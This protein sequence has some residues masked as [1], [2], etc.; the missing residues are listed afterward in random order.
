M[1]KNTSIDIV[2]ENFQDMR[3]DIPEFSAKNMHYSMSGVNPFYYDILNS[4]QE[5]QFSPLAASLQATDPLSTALPATITNVVPMFNG[6]LTSLP[7]IIIA[8]NAG[9]IKN[10]LANTTRQPFGAGAQI[11][12]V[13]PFGGYAIM[14]SSIS[15]QIAYCLLGANTVFTL[16]T[17]TV[18]GVG[19]KYLCAFLD[20]LLIC[21]S[22]NVFLMTQP[23]VEPSN[24]PGLQL[25]S[26]YQI[27]AP[28]EV[29][30]NY[31]SIPG[32]ADLYSDNVLFLWNGYGTTYQYNV[33]LP[34]RFIGQTNINGVLFVVVEEK[35]GIQ[36][37]FYVK[38]EVL[39]RVRKLHGLHT[40]AN[41][42]IISNPKLYPVFNANGYVCILTDQGVYFYKKDVY[43][44]VSFIYN[45]N[46]YNAGAV[47]G[48]SNQLYLASGTNLYNDLSSVFNPV[49]YNSQYIPV[50]PG[51][52]D[53]WYDTPPQ[54]GTDAIN[55]TLYGIDEFGPEGGLAN[56]NFPL[57]SITPLNTLGSDSAKR[58]TLDC[59][60][61]T[62][63]KCRISLSTV[64]SAWQP[65]IRKLVITP[66][67]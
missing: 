1:A 62:G 63:Q 14:V 39:I 48:L 64:N 43:G 52:I 50:T 40:T 61:F 49:V 36:S 8:D 31:V 16:I 53:V 44:E 60:G 3:S 20:Y 42:I 7:D 25:P 66:A 21:Q 59:T 47:G 38:G 57:T 13:L 27:I 35:S 54:S 32:A 41:S 18:V 12:S 65:I 10:G 11:V 51:K 6:A 28:P 4:T 24:V 56:T 23:T 46:N 22:N 30:G 37:L 17:G 34:G 55:I 58:F 26:G 2:I 29:Y 15:A 19:N 9:N 33:P 67:E 45:A 5:E